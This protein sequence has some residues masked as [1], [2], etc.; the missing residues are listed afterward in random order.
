MTEAQGVMLWA[1]IFIRINYISKRLVIIRKTRFLSI[2]DMGNKEHSTLAVSKRRED[3]LKHIL[4]FKSHGYIKHHI[5]AQ[6]NIGYKSIENDITIA[7]AT[8]E[9]DFANLAPQII[10]KH[11]AMYYSLAEEAKLN[12]DPKGAATILEKIEKLRKMHLPSTQINIQ[13]N[14]YNVEALSE[15]DIRK[16][17]DETGQGEA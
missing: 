7:Y 6:Y 2:N 17:L 16:F 3:V 11:M 14:T 12:G 4:D 1:F 15:E 13:S 10:A 9:T 5:N 8:L